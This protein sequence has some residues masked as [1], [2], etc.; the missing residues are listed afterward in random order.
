MRNFNHTMDVLVKA[1]LNNTLMHMECHACAVGNIINDALPFSDLERKELKYHDDGWVRVFCTFNG[2]AQ[3]QT[4]NPEKYLGKAKKQID[5][6]GYTWQELARIEFAFETAPKGETDDDWMFNGLLA[7]LEVLADI[8]KVDF[9]GQQVYE[10][11]LAE[12]HATR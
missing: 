9:S 4:Q 11:Q 6:T 2:G 5:A 10:R 12:I 7:V 1:Y 3:G 8:H